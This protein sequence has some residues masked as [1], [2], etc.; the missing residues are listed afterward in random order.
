VQVQDG[1]QRREVIDKRQK[2]ISSELVHYLPVVVELVNPYFGESSSTPN[3]LSSKER[4]VKNDKILALILELSP[5][6]SVKSGKDVEARDA[7][8][9][10]K[11]SIET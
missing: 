11:E 7:H 10:A 5:Q 4:R 8:H 9:E 6:V 1:S 3:Q 2:F